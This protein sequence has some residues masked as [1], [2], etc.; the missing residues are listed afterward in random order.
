V[1]VGAAMSDWTRL[2]VNSPIMQTHAAIVASEFVRGIVARIIFF[3]RSVLNRSFLLY[4]MMVNYWWS[5]RHWT[6]V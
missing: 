5:R 4:V 6:L 2:D 3:M 1:S